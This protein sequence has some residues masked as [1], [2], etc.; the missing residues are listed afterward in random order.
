M[1]YIEALFRFYLYSTTYLVLCDNCDVFFGNN[2][3]IWCV[4]TTSGMPHG[5]AIDL[6]VCSEDCT[7]GSFLV[8][9]DGR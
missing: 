4:N 8:S 6:V 2:L 9:S 7:C 5:S 1:V 3:F